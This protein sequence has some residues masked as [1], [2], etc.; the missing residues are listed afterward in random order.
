MKMTRNYLAV[1]VLVALGSAACTD[2]AR[3]SPTSPSAAAQASAVADA[4]GVTIDKTSNVVRDAE[5][6]N[7]WAGQHG[8]QT[9]DV[10]FEVEGTDIVTAVTGTCPNVVMTI[11]GVPV[12]VNSATTFAAGGACSGITVSRTLHVRGLLTYTEANGFNVTATAITFSDSTETVT[13]EGAVTTV[14]GTCP[15]V[16]IALQG[17]ASAVATATTTYTPATGCANIVAATRVR[18][19]GT[20]SA[21]GSGPITATA[22]EVLQVPATH[23]GRVT[24]ISG[25]CPAITLSFDG[26]VSAIA[27]STTA[28]APASSCG[29]IV[30]GSTVSVTGT[31]AGSAT[32]AI[33]ATQ[34]EVTGT[35]LEGET[36]V[37]SITGTC[38]SLTLM[39]EVGGSAITSSTTAFSPA[40]SSITAGA[41]VHVRGYQ[42]SLGQL[43]LSDVRLLTE[44]RRR[45]GGESNV[46]AVAGTCPALTLTVAGVRVVTNSSTEFLNGACST[47]RTGT[48]VHVEGYQESD[49]SVTAT[50]IRITEQPGNGGG[51]RVAGEGKVDEVT[52]TCPAATFK[53]RNYNVVATPT[54]TYTGGVCADI[55]SGTT[56]AASGTISGHTLTAESIRIVSQGH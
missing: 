3:R 19:T 8:W 31:R 2:G 6:I 17:G 5:I 41:R 32:G 4:S 44:V 14:T 16:T 10:G 12:T 23:M 26:G 25:T 36:R 56:I 43:V 37:S 9:L 18:I 50:S 51:Q 40:C 21:T 20:R 38:P 45:V 39:L 27:S 53:V 42:N 48:K 28:F 46:Q 30:V 29:I 35:P 34:I 22:I 33:T 52:G 24:A 1:L 47:I 54:T 49:G 13:V 15:A 7:D 11:R 55:R